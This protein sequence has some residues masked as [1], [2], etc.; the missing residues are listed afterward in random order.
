MNDKYPFADPPE[1]YT[2]FSNTT[3][4]WT[5]STKDDAPPEQRWCATHLRYGTKYFAEHD[6]ILPYTLNNMVAE[7]KQ[8][9]SR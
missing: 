2:H 9:W 3:S 4:G 6:D 1:G 8:R 7:L 5:I